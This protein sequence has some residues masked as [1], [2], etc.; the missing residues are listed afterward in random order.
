MR[1]GLI[2][3]NRES[4]RAHLDGKVRGQKQ[5]RGCVVGIGGG[6]SSRVTNLRSQLARNDKLKAATVRTPKTG[7]MP[8][9]H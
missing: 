3:I 2:S 9:L 8:T 1:R 4:Y 5:D 7:S 6:K